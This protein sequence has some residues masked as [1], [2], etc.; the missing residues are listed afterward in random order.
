MFNLFLFMVLLTLAIRFFVFDFV[1]FK[2][3]RNWLKERGWFFRKLLSC[4]FCQG[5][6]TGLIIYAVLSPYE[7]TLMAFIMHISYGFIT[8]Y[9]SLVIT[10]WLDPHLFEYETINGA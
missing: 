9:L 7:F 2:R 3:P 8:A 4:P 10:V 6:W 1:L 5:F